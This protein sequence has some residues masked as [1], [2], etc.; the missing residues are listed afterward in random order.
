MHVIVYAT[1]EYPNAELVIEQDGAKIFSEH[2]ALSP[3]EVYDRKIPIGSEHPE[4]LTFKVRS[5]GRTLVH[6]TPQRPGTAATASP[7]EAAR[8]PAQID[9]NEE[10]LLTAQHIEQHRHA[11]Y[12]PDPYYEEGLRRD[13]DDI[14]IN[15]AYGM[16]LLR[17]GQFS[18][19]EKTLPRGDTPHDLAQSKPI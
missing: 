19:A 11:T 1:S 13:P 12:L 2:I 14:R 5:D 4:E 7:A 9:T 6:Y 18:T 17:R 8:E 16:L 15:N 3:V 10:L